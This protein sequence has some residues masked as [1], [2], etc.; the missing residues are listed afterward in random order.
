MSTSSVERRRRS[1][2]RPPPIWISQA[3]TIASDRCRRGES[4]QKGVQ[5][6]K[7]KKKKRG[8][9]SE[10]TL[11]DKRRELVGVPG[12][13]KVFGVD[14]HADRKRDSAE[15]FGQVDVREAIA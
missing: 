2:A 9:G 15:R 14:V 12:C 1:E 7:K 13:G 3:S 11:L 5:K 4:K 6:K 10:R 8:G